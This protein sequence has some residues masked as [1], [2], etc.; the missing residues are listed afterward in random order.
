M[1]K[2]GTYTW[3]GESGQKYVYTRYSTDT[4]WKKEVSAN[5]ICASVEGSTF[6]A[7]YIG[8]TEDLRKR[9]SNHEKWPCCKQYG[10]NEIHI[11]RDAES[12][13]ERLEQ[14]DDLV[15]N[16]EPPCNG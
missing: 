4:A 7:V 12:E 2:L 13:E 1:S 8:Q 3:T 5:Y 10:V 9:M 15:D 14:E 11:N 6:D 16:Y